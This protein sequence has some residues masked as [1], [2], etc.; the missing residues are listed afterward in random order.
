MDEKDYLEYWTKLK[1]EV[2]TFRALDDKRLTFGAWTCGWGHKFETL[3]IVSGKEIADFE[4]RTGLD[5][6]V[7]Y[8]TYLQSFGAGGGNS[9]SG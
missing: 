3:P 2:A 8:R 6:P 5:L 9:V 7:E 4:R 1:S